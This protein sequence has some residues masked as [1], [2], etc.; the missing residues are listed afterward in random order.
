MITYIAF[1]RAINVAGH[2][3]IRMDELKKMFAAAGC[4]NVRTFIQ[5]GNVVFESPQDHSPALLQK[6]RL[7]LRESSGVQ[8]GIFLRTAG[9]VER[10]VKEEPFRAFE[11][12]AAV[13]FC[14]SFLSQRPSIKPRFPLVSAPEAV[15][16]F[17]M[18]GLEVFTVSRRK[19]NDFYGSPNNFIEK[20]LGVSATTRNW[21]TV[22]RVVEFA[23]SS[24]KLI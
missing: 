20:E 16:A 4:K 22:R 7:R 3:I 6:I 17:A 23:G 10:I 1:L 12:E 8:P 2:A 14:V 19:K 24:L 18:K 11:R 5:S 21:T 13:K 15:E 9:E